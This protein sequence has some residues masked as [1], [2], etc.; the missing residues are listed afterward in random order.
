MVDI[1]N[2]RPEAAFCTTVKNRRLHMEVTLPHNL[3]VLA[4][5]NCQLI[6]V[7]FDS[8][9][10][11]INFVTHS[12]QRE[13]ALEKLVYYTVSP[14]PVYERSKSR[15]IAF[16]LADTEYVCNLDAD[17]FLGMNF[18]NYAK[19]HLQ[20]YDFLQGCKELEDDC[21]F[22]HGTQGASGRLVTRKSVFDSVG[23]YDQTLQGYG[24]EDLDIYK[25]LEKAGYSG[26]I[27]D[28][29]IFLQSIDHDNDLRIKHHELPDVTVAH[30][31][32]KYISQLNIEDG[33]YK[34]N[35]GERRDNLKIRRLG[36]QQ[37][38]HISFY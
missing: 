4:E 34:A 36:Q 37:E 20:T 31:I 19:K 1:K 10:F 15:N 28:E 3:R 25:R 27:I 38:S 12:F 14:A 35:V 23:G 17:N 33:S 13:L 8:D 32:N 29:C 21:L 26:K 30:K 9:D 11:L 2:Q 6:I 22:F 5:T 7:D 18:W 24:Y 16:S